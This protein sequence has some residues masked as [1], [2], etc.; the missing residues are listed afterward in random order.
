MEIT[1]QF[2]E[3][4]RELEERMRPQIDEA[5]KRLSDLNDSAVS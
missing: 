3:T 4:A 2:E 1:S 5:K